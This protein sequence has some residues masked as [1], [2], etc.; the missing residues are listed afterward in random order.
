MK[1]NKTWCVQR[2]RVA[3]I[4]FALAGVIGGLLGFG[5][6]VNAQHRMHGQQEPEN[7]SHP[8]MNA[9]L[10]PDERADM[11]LKEMTLD[12]K[13]LLLHGQG[14]PGWPREVQN[15]Q[16]ELGNGGAGFIMGIPRLGIPFVQMSDAAY[17]VRSSA[18][19]GDIRRRCRP[20]WER[21]R[22]GTRRQRANLEQ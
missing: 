7:R 18:E 14:M 3:A 19:N 4:A 21:R 8:W 13:I 15:P 17:G 9:S 11:V 6:T 5:K 12:E 1:I 20:T 16:P 2:G 10:S 22:A